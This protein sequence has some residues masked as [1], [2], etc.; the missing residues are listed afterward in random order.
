MVPRVAWNWPSQYLP[1][2]SRFWRVI[3]S[4]RVSARRVS[5]SGHQPPA[6]YRALGHVPLAHLGWSWGVAG[7]RM[8][9]HR[10]TPLQLAGSWLWPTC[11]G[12][13]VS[14]RI[15]QHRMKIQS[16]FPSSWPLTLCGIESHIIVLG[17][18]VLPIDEDGWGQAQGNGVLILGV[19]PTAAVMAWS[20]TSTTIHSEEPEERY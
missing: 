13:A 2:T 1:L 14:H 9:Q 12:L 5:A 3:V 4:G 10:P 6:A 15:F 7:P 18:I 16:Y 11:T 19:P 17:K 8:V 20:R